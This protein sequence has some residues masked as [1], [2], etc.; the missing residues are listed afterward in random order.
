MFG[1][2]ANT[3]SGIS[4]TAERSAIVRLFLKIRSVERFVGSFVLF[5][6]V[7]EHGENGNQDVDVNE[8]AGEQKIFNNAER[9]EGLAHC[10]ATD[11]TEK[12]R[13]LLF[14]IVSIPNVYNED[15]FKECTYKFMMIINLE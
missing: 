12:T 6:A 10:R 8:D 9:V 7:F 13:Q 11:Y 4:G 2:R 15:F 1:Y 5:F 14:D 3:A